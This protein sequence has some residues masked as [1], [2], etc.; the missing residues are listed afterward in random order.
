M[1]T[2]GVFTT[3]TFQFTQ[4]NDLII[5]LLNGNIVVLDTLEAFLH[6]VQLVIVRSKQRTCLCFR[7]FMDMLYNCPGNRNTVVRRCTSSQLVK[8][9]Q[10]ARRKVI[11]NISRLIH[12]HHESRLS[13]RDI[14]TGT[15]TGKYLIYQTDMCT[16][17][18]YEAA[19]LRQ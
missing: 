19:N 1:D 15:Y 5:H 8:K 6:L 12:F 11:Q 4:E 9:H 16:L 10:T 3:A 13:D 7:V 18:R 17:G 2:K 14:I